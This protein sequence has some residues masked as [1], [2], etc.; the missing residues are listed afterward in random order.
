MELASKLTHN[1]FKTNFIFFVVSSGQGDVL[2]ISN[3][4]KER[5]TKKG[6]EEAM[7]L[8]CPT[9]Q[10]KLIA[11]Y[12]DVKVSNSLQEAEKTHDSPS[13]LLSR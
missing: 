3:S 6:K 9:L 10:K 7:E 8:K 13:T 1:I 11:V 4:S 5:D 12:E 2:D